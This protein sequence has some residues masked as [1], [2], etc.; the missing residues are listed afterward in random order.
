MGLEERGGDREGTGR[1]GERETA[2]RMQYIRRIKV[3]LKEILESIIQKSYNRCRLTSA[4]RNIRLEWRRWLNG[5]EFKHSSISGSHV[6]SFN[7]CFRGKMRDGDMRI[8]WKFMGELTWNMQR[9]V[10]N[11]TKETQLDKE[12]KNQSLKVV[13]R[14]PHVHCDTHVTS[15][16]LAH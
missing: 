9:R 3:F 10:R 13:L 8:R 12:S 2:V 7:P 5:L 16:T 11:L 4:P 15:H 14:P 1:I 6:G